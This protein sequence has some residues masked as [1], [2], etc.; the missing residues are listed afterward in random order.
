M[1]LENVMDSGITMYLECDEITASAGEKKESEEEY[2]T[3]SMHAAEQDLDY[4]TTI[5]DNKFG[6]RRPTDKSAVEASYDFDEALKLVGDYEGF[7]IWFRR[8]KYWITVLIQRRPK[9]NGFLNKFKRHLDFWRLYHNMAASDTDVL[10]D[11]LEVMQ[12]FW[13]KNAKKDDPI[14][15]KTD[16]LQDPKLLHLYK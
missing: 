11:D 3:V 2:G 4:D 10:E 9:S 12:D 7:I 1:V 13:S 14:K 6:H 15:M 16:E 5:K 8:Q